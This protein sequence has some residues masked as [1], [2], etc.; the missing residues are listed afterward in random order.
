MA[1]K[2]V[3]IGLGNPILSDDGIGIFAVREIKKRLPGDFNGD[4][5]EASL[6]GFNLLDLL[7]GYDEAIIVDS[8]QTKDGIVGEVYEFEPQA[9]KE[10]VRLAS[11]HDLNL[12]TAL[13][14]GKRLDLPVPKKVLIFA[15]EVED[16]V[17]FREG[18]CDK[19]AA[20]IPVIVERVTGYLEENRQIQTR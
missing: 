6:A 14:L 12:V 11:I 17:T 9:L 8:I 18:C 2:T 19:V 1:V 16:N 15:V 10:T 3:I 13:E 7:L 5:R 20:A 4:I